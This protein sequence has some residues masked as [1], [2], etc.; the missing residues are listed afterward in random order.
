MTMSV[1]SVTRLKDP[2]VRRKFGLQESTS[3]GDLSI[4]GYTFVLIISRTWNANIFK[5]FI[6]SARRMK[7]TRGTDQLQ[8]PFLHHRSYTV[9]I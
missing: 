9:S 3:G 7:R 8:Y 5:L 1:F 2:W 4:S 6:C